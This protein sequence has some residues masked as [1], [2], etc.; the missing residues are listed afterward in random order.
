MNI[1]KLNDVPRAQAAQTTFGILDQF[2]RQK[3]RPEMIAASTACLMMLV[4]RRYGVSPQKL[5]EVAN[6][7]I[8]DADKKQ[9]PEFAGVARYL[10]EEA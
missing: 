2:D 10:R 7:L 8:H 3:V 9:V 5:W 1:D 4:A 6:N